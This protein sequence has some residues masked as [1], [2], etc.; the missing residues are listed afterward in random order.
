MKVFWEIQEVDFRR[1]TLSNRQMRAYPF[2]EPRVHRPKIDFPVCL[3]KA[4]TRD[5]IGSV[6]PKE[7]SK[8]I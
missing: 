3:Y 4:K 7:A 8:R 1:V 2:D 6:L 5:I